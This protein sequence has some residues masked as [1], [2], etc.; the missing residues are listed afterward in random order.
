MRRY[1]STVFALVSLLGCLLLVWHEIS[2]DRSETDRV[3]E[4]FSKYYSI[5]SDARS[6]TGTL[7]E[8]EAQQFSSLDS[9][10]AQESLNESPVGLLT[11][12]LMVGD[13]AMLL[14]AR[15]L[16]PGDRL[17]LIQ[18]ALV[19]DQSNS[20]ELTRLE[21]L[22]PE[23]SL[24]NLIRASLYAEGGD[25]IRFREE[26]ERA[27]SK[28]KLDTAYRQRQGLI[29]DRIIAEDMRNI[30][31]AVYLGLDSGVLDRLEHAAEALIDNPRLFGDEY[32]SAGYAVAF[33]EKLRA[34]GGG[35]HEF[36]LAAG[37]LE[38]D[39]LRR[40]DPRDGYVVEGKTVGQHLA[41]MERLVPALRQ[42]AEQYLDP[43]MS[44]GGDPVLRLQFFARVRSAGEVE[45]LGWLARK[46]DG[47]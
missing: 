26:L 37:Q 27:M 8:T 18:N 42:R 35:R 45:A 15:R 21:E 14:R 11:D 41:E 19:T 20:P 9:V 39:V 38:I 10:D 32:E 28:G 43:L 30:D 16:F 46:V 36:G 7:R 5:G 47:L 22:E 31:P 12:F 2:G 29:L 40:L 1:V 33:A 23:N 34:M 6:S 25:M 44:P 4:T 3:S 24:P 13:Q 17:I